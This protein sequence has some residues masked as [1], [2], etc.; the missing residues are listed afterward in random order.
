MRGMEDKQSAPSVR[1]Q[2]ARADIR[3]P[4]PDEP[5]G[6]PD[7]H[8]QELMLEVLR[9]SGRLEIRRVREDGPPPTDPDTAA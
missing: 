3:G 5:S 4:H 8:P 1:K 6:P 7:L 9:I 2:P